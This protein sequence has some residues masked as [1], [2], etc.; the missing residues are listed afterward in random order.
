MPLTSHRPPAA[1]LLEAFSPKL[2]RRV[3]LYDHTSFKLW[4]SLEADAEV[5]A[6]CER[7][8]ALNGD[9]GRMIEFWVQREELL[10]IENSKASAALPDRFGEIAVERGKSVN[11]AEPG[12]RSEVHRKID[13]FTLT[14]SEA[15]L[16]TNDRDR[17]RQVCQ[18]AARAGQT[19]RN[20][21]IHRMSDYLASRRWRQPQILSITESQPLLQPVAPV[22]R[23]HPW[24]RS[25][26]IVSS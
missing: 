20:P 1:R 15:N 17:A 13:T 26:Q 9:A 6:L 12:I 7:P 23:A 14:L 5:K 22:C 16:S 21:L 25:K 18:F 8:V 3:R 24:H 11:I 4:I 10:L 2:A 19:V